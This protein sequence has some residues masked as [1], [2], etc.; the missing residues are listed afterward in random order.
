MSIS[1]R[2]RIDGHEIELVSDSWYFREPCI[3][4]PLSTAEAIDGSSWNAILGELVERAHFVD[5]LG[6]ADAMI[7]YSKMS[8]R[9]SGLIPGDI[10]DDHLD[11]I[12]KLKKFAGQDE[13]ID[14]AIMIVDAS[15]VAARLAA[16]RKAVKA[17]RIQTRTQKVRSELQANYHKTLVQLGRRDGF[18]CATC[19]SSEAD[20]QIDHVMPVSKGGMNNL[21]NLQL[22]CRKCNGK[23]SDT[24]EGAQNG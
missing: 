4:I 22:L 11:S 20:L 19:F 7:Q 15:I 23:K 17:A 24:F 14:K 10:L 9:N 1:I 21:D 2:V 3:V 5:A 16:E 12:D 13:Q 6:I 8:D 18:H